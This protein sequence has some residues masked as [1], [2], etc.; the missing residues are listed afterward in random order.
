M[1]QV[2]SLFEKLPYLGNI[3]PYALQLLA[4]FVT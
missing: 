1:Q 4:C 2:S 3:V